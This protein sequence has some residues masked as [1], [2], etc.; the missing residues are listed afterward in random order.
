MTNLEATVLTQW[1]ATD[2]KWKEPDSKEG[3]ITVGVHRTRM[4]VQI[5]M[6]KFWKQ[7]MEKD[8]QIT[9]NNHETLRSK[10]E[11]LSEEIVGLKRK[12][13]G[14]AANT[15]AA[16]PGS[17]GNTRNF[18]SHVVPNTSLPTRVELKGWVWVE[19]HS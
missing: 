11:R 12:H 6:E 15:V 3:T 16:S 7:R 2:K 9:T 18:A 10:V 1:T 13:N 17:G 5:Q 14:N 8:D 19:E 4:S